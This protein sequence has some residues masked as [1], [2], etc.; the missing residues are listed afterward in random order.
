MN[1]SVVT[2]VQVD[3]RRRKKLEDNNEKL[4]SVFTV[5]SSGG[6]LSRRDFALHLSSLTEHPKAA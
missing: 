2:S 4:P 5:L 6:K 1:L 3:I